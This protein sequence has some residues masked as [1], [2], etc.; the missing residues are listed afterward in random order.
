MLSFTDGTKVAGSLLVGA[1][2]A[3][4]AVRQQYLPN[5][6]LLDTRRRTI[7]GKTPPTLSLKNRI[8]PETL[9]RLSFIR[10]PEA[11]SLTLVEALHFLPKS[12]RIGQHVLPHDYIYGTII[13]PPVAY[14]C[15]QSLKKN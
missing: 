1:D 6:R 4:S 12:Q 10:D 3:R 9:K 5:F 11:G 8:L 14:C 13:P 2:G 15:T 7:Y